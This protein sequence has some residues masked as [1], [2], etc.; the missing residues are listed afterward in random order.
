[1]KRIPQRTLLAC[2][3]GLMVLTSQDVPAFQGKKK[4]VLRL[5]TT[6]S[7]YETG[8]LDH[9]L[10]PFEKKHDVKIHIIS[11]GTGKAMKI[12]E[13]GDV[14]V[15]LVHARKAEDKFIKDGYGVN[16]RDV[17]YNDF[18][19]MGP[20]NDPGGIAGLKDA[21][22]ALRNIHDKQ[23]T[24]VSRGDDSGTHKKEKSLW[25]QLKLSPRGKWYLE[26]GQGMTATLRMADEKNAYVMVDRATYLSNRNKLRLRLLV[27]GDK[28]LFN[29]Y[30]IIPVNPFKHK[31]AKYKIAMA[32]VA[33]M[34]SPECQKMIGEY[35][36]KGQQL[37]HPNA[38]N[39]VK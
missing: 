8:L 37:Y 15:I 32:L 22:L 39:P 3:L 7:T 13:N 23:Q 21:K 28:D 31:H 30:G 38:E 19:I 10:P 35:K 29:P 25:S 33:W 36:T 34:T 4:T 24:F 16:R 1:M 20:K 6:T 17:M 14:D 9:I 11:V 5:A 12:A 27:E 26:A 18:V 2:V